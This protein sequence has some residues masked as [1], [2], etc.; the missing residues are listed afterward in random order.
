[1]AGRH[2]KIAQAFVVFLPVRAVGVM[3]D[4]RRY[5]YVVRLWAVETQGLHDRALGAAAGGTPE[6]GG[7]GDHER[8]RE[9]RPGLLRYL[10]QATGHRGVGIISHPTQA[11]IC[12]H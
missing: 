6:P 11:S 4:G 7:T 12:K 2:D 10:E 8:D 1:M 9:H 3:G 5:D